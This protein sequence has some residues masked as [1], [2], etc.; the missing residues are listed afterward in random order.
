MDAHPQRP[1]LWLRLGIWHHLIRQNEKIFSRFCLL[2]PQS[3]LSNISF[4]L[5]IISFKLHLPF[6]LPTQEL[7]RKCIQIKSCKSLNFNF[8]ECQTYTV[9]KRDNQ[10]EFTVEHKELHSISYN[11][12]GKKSEN[13]HVYVCVMGPLCCTSET[14]TTL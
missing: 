9:Y 6:L 1:T 7:Y 2:C 11:Y 5:I 3:Y 13:T 4:K 12:N 8:K 10:Q 14:N